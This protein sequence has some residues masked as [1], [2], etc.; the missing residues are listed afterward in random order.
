MIW[1]WFVSQFDYEL[2]L[3]ITRC[4]LILSLLCSLHDLPY[5]FATR[6]MVLLD[7]LLYVTW[8]SWLLDC[9]ELNLTMISLLSKI[10]HN[11]LLHKDITRWTIQT[12]ILNEIFNNDMD[13]KQRHI[14]LASWPFPHSKRPERNQI[15]ITQLDN[16]RPELDSS[17]YC[18]DLISI[19]PTHE[20]NRK[21]PASP[22]QTYN[23]TISTPHDHETWP[24]WKLIVSNTITWKKKQT[25]ADLIEL[26]MFLTCTRPV[27][28]NDVTQHDWTC[29]ESWDDPTYPTRV[30]KLTA[31]VK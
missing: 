29:P 28:L 21:A 3:I 15:I 1:T 27:W 18:P 24:D 4:N 6:Y 7:L 17:R 31:L 5:I 9:W 11:T 30:T 10:N 19:R 26:R 23:K 25:E 12:L 13:L 20:L 22:L 16:Y 2:N 14:S 8:F